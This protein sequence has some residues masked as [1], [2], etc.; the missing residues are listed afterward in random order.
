MAEE[1]RCQAPRLCANNCGFFGS[2]A[3]QDLCSKCYRDLQLKEERSSSAKLVLSQTLIPQAVVSQEVVVQPSSSEV[4]SSLPAVEA[5]AGTSEQ[6]NPNRCGSC[7]RRVG[8]T[9]FKCRCGL[10]LCGSHRY[11]EQHGCGFDFKGMGRE[12]IAKA[13]PLVKGEKLNKI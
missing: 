1:H 11:P 12:Q 13:N 3:M 7:R 4:V 5:V 2:P 9:G 6:P 8:L 10:T